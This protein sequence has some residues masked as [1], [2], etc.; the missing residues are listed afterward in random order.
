MLN[1][2]AFFYQAVTQKS[3]YLYEFDETKCLK[4]SQAGFRLQS[5]NAAKFT[6]FKI[7]CGEISW[8]DCGE[9]GARGEVVISRDLIIARV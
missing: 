2:I 8:I 6:R 4:Y 9:L 7:C 3:I 1:M 5:S